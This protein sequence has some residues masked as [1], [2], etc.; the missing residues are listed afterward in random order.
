MPPGRPPRGSLRALQSGDALKFGRRVLA[1]ANRDT[2]RA[3]VL[4]DY[5][6]RARQQTDATLNGTVHCELLDYFTTIEL[7]VYFAQVHIGATRKIRTG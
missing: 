3:L 4:K 2:E 6:T 1:L 7:Q 5:A